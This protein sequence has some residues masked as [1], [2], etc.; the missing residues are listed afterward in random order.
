[1]T[2]TKGFADLPYVSL[3]GKLTGKLRTLAFSEGGGREWLVWNHFATTTSDVITLNYFDQN[4]QEACSNHFFNTT[5]AKSE[6]SQH[7]LSPKLARFINIS[8]FVSATVFIFHP[9]ASL[10][11]P[12]T[13]KLFCAF[14]LWH[15]E[16]M[17][18]KYYFVDKSRMYSIENWNW[19]GKRATASEREKDSQ[20]IVTDAPGERIKWD[21][22]DKIK[23][24]QHILDQ[25]HA[26]IIFNKASM[27]VR[28]EMT[29]AVESSKWFVMKL[30]T[31]V[32]EAFSTPVEYAL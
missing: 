14:I 21:R 12:T 15:V 30:S 1:M 26:V 20:F 22:C 8:I 6:G 29:S 17:Q 23:L 27:H 4:F 19:G 11:S 2:P 28:H 25:F 10:P 16:R 24:A 13:E 3:L 18:L 9:R 5:L 32:V 7:H 31:K